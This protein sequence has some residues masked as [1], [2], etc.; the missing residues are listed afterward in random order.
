ER[1]S[2]ARPRAPPPALWA[3]NSFGGTTTL[4]GN[5]GGRV[6]EG[7]GKNWRTFN[8]PAPKPFSADAMMFDPAHGR[9]VAV[10]A[11]PP[12]GME[13]WLY[14]TRG[15]DS[16][17]ASQC[18]TGSSVNGACWQQSARQGTSTARPVARKRQRLAGLC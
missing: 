9:T 7:D 18:D 3:L 6:W 16:T 10:Y 11:P 5:P 17:A 12:A 2:A 4:Y 1:P 13:T 15:R 8:P 14:Y